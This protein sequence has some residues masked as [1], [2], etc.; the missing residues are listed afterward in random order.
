MAGLAL[1]YSQLV[2][3]VRPALVNGA[4][5]LV[6]RDDRSRIRSE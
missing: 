3:L 2:L 4:A 5:G 6:G 1:N